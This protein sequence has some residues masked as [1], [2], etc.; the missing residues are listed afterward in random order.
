MLQDY[1]QG[2]LASDISIGDLA[3]LLGLSRTQFLRRFKASTGTSPY[4]RV[5]EARVERAKELL[6]N[7]RMNLSEIAASCG[8]ANQAHL[9]TVFQRFVKLSPSAFRRHF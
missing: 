8:F 4:Q 1:I 5:M 6:A 3:N 7:P 2:H 9:A